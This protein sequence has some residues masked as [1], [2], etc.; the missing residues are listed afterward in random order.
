MNPND[1]T[2]DTDASAQAPAADDQTADI[3]DTP[4]AASVSDPNQAP[5][6]AKCDKCGEHDVVDGKCSGCQTD[7]TMCACTPTTQGGPSEPA[8]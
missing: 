1:T 5:V 6:A 8:V 2:E 7:A 4:P 3:G